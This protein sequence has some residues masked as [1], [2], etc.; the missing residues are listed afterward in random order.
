[1]T[2]L[3]TFIANTLC[4]RFLALFATPS[5]WQRRKLT[6]V[7]YQPNQKLVIDLRKYETDGVFDRII[8]RLTG[9]VTG[10][11]T[12]AATGLDDP[13]GLLLNASMVV[14]PAPQG[15]VPFNQVSGR[16]LLIDRAMEDQT[17][18]KAP[19]ITALSATTATASITLD[20]E[21]HLIFQRRFLKKGIEYGFDMGRY[22][23]A[24]L[25]LTFGDLSS[26]YTGGTGVWTAANV[27][28][29]ADVNYNVNPDHLHAVEL[30]ENIYTISASNPAML[31][32]NLPN[33]A[34]YGDLVVLS[35]LN[36][37]LDNRPVGG[38]TRAGAPTGGFDLSSGSRIWLQLGDNNADYLQRRTRELYDGS[39]FNVD[40]PNATPTTSKTCYGQFALTRLGKRQNLLTKAPEALTSQLLIK[41]AVTATATSQLRLF[42]RKI[43]PGGVYSKP[44]SATA[45]K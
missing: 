32:D 37:A 20:C 34:Y 24:V 31:I 14:T 17:L 7:G 38:A 11:N 18:V 43:V 12:G 29:W 30:F 1:M 2:S 39:M 13:E 28:I 8:V 5:Q 33:G 26:I 4:T 21:W 45:S 40:D 6:T 9:A 19:A 16:T 42:G 35:E 27:E 23:G 22:T 36:Q 10:S 3:L 44:K 25:N 41:V 15:L